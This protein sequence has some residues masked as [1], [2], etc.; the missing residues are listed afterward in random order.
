MFRGAA[1][2][3]REVKIS[4]IQFINPSLLWSRHYS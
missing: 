4:T 2:Y 1:S 3:K